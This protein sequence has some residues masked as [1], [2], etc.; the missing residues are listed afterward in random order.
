MAKMCQKLPT[1]AHFCDFKA[2]YRPLS[3]KMT[4]YSCRGG[5]KLWFAWSYIKIGRVLRSEMRKMWSKHPTCTLQ[6]PYTLYGVEDLKCCYLWILMWKFEIW[7]VKSVMRKS[8]TIFCFVYNVKPP[9]FQRFQNKTTAV[10][11]LC[12]PIYILVIQAG[13][14]FLECGSIRAKNATNIL[15]K[16]LL[17]SC[18][19]LPIMYKSTPW[20]KFSLFEWK[21][22]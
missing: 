9:P 12:I 5:P 1:S 3:G 18:K 4:L 14:G 10:Q 21:S 7:S 11:F 19:N 22:S 2:C 8:T 15:L 16:N 13:F 6:W 17:D 20:S